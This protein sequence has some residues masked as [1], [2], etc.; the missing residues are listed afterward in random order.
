MLDIETGFRIDDRVIAWG[1]TLDEAC[2][3]L[4][5]PAAHSA[6]GDIVLRSGLGL[7]LPA[8]S[9]RLSAPA[10]DRPVLAVEYAL[11]D[12]GGFR[13]DDW[14]GA[15]SDLFGPPDHCVRRAIAEG[16]RP[17]DGVVLH[18]RWPTG[19]FRASVS[20]F[21]APRQVAHGLSIGTLWLSWSEERAAAPYLAEWHAR[22]GQLAA[23]AADPAEIEIHPLDW[24]AYP[25]HG[26]AAG[27]LETE[28]G[29]QRRRRLLCL[30]APDLLETPGEIAE[31]LTPSHFAIW[32]PASVRVWCASTLW[33][34]VVFPLDEPVSVTRIEMLPAKGG[35]YGALEIGRWNVRSAQGSAAIAAAEA[36]IAAFP[37]VS[38]VRH[39]GYDC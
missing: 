22:A 36:T 16:Q 3:L 24:P 2:R 9:A 7:G 19:D 38:I 34:T 28:E 5:V 17:Q 4:G 21:G 20:I 26:R 23:S 29:R 6:S 12:V 10:A 11:A 25:A 13:P 35:G 1:V 31:R 30:H 8:V 18:A 27:G 15:V 32:R 37:G 33:D 39:D 14:I